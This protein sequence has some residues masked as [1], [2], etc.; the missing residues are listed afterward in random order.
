MLFHHLDKQR[1]KG[2]LILRI[3]IG[4]MFMCHGFPKLAGGP[5]VWTKLGGALGALGIHFEP[6]THF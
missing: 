2:L 6:T 5:E 4:V 3:G 1:D